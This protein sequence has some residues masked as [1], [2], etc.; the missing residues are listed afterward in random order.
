MPTFTGTSD[1]AD[2]EDSV[3]RFK[4]RALLAK[5]KNV[6]QTTL[7]RRLGITTVGMSQKISKPG[8]ITVMDA[9]IIADE[10]DV[11][12]EELLDYQAVVEEIDR[13]RKEAGLLMELS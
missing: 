11:M 12:L 10:L 9:V 2:Y 5:S 6:T 3:L 8:R 4:V 7:A 13:Q 1:H